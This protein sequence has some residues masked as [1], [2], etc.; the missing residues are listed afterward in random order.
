MKPDGGKTPAPVDD[1]PLEDIARATGRSLL[2]DT[3]SWIHRR[4]ERVRYTER[5]TLKWHFSVDLTIKKSFRP[6]EEHADGSNTYF[7]PLALLR[8]WPPL[9]NLDLRDERDRPLPLLTSEKNRRV[10]AA[11]LAGVAAGKAASPVATKMLEGVA[12]AT[13]IEEAEARLNGLANHVESEVLPG[14]T[15]A[16]AADDWRR[17]L[18]LSTNFAWNSLLWARIKGYPGQRQLVKVGFERMMPPAAPLRRR[19]PSTFGVRG[20]WIRL[21]LYNLGERESYHLEFI[22]PKGT[23]VLEARLQVLDPLTRRQR[24]KWHQLKARRHRRQ[25]RRQ[26]RESYSGTA[27]KRRFGRSLSSL[28][29]DPSP[30][31]GK[32][33]AYSLN[34]VT[35]AHFYV[36]ESAGQR[37]KAHIRLGP[38]RREFL[39]GALYA[40]VLT[41][42][43]LWFSFFFAENLVEKSH[44]APTVTALLLLPALLS[45]L[46]TQPL[47]HPIA[48]RMIAGVRIVT[49]TVTLLPVAAALIM[50]G[51]TT[52]TGTGNPEVGLVEDW[53]MG[54]AILASLLTMLLGLT[55][56]LLP[57][58]A[59][60]ELYA[61][62]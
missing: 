36:A 60:G 30:L 56:K 52:A 37:G 46:F 13:S 42:A 21:D 10:D 55:A 19:L 61:P 7:L 53:W 9:M 38:T 48:R 25:Q 6:F 40:S 45:Y 28:S 39:T 59:V 16:N 33:T 20:E 32:G 51:L 15:T 49:R 24:P 44:Q 54:L 23:D 14:L 29:S 35:R 1:S 22:P 5:E 11:A 26:R 31:P 57:R 34:M 27:T 62:Y 50:L 8:K 3:T 12:T 47:P 58:A 2:L 41:T 43:L 18:L 4:V 17:I